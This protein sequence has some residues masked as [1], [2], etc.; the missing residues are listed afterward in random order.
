MNPCRFDK[1][2]V[3]CSNTVFAVIMPYQHHE[4]HG[5]QTGKTRSRRDGIHA[6]CITI[7][8]EARDYLPLMYVAAN[9]TLIDDIATG[10]VK[11]SDFHRRLT[12]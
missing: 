7:D 10:P 6:L 3:F 8:E 11:V 4:N 2:A 5:F 12:R 1:T 9:Y